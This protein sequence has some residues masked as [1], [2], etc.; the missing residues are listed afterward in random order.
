MRTRTLTGLTV[1]LTAGGLAS[2]AV[3]MHVTGSDRA[4]AGGIILTTVALLP[5]IAAGSRHAATRVATLTAE[6]AAAE[7]AAGYRQGLTHAA[8]GLLEPDS[9]RV[10]D[11]ERT[12]Q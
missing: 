5:A 9:T 8:A 6:Q 3:G 7:R 12:Q 11:T 10:D 1:A 2:A 4:I